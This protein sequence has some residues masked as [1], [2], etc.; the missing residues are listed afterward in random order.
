MKRTRSAFNVRPLRPATIEAILAG[1]H[2]EARVQHV[3]VVQQARCGDGVA[4]G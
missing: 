3:K 2:P 4:C 1:R